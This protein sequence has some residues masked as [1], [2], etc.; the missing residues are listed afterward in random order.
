MK[1]AQEGIIRLIIV[2]ACPAASLEISSFDFSG[3]VL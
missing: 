2:D 3:E 1:G